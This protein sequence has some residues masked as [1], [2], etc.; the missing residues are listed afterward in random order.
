MA[1][2][3]SFSTKPYDEAAAQADLRAL[4]NRL[5]RFNPETLIRACADVLNHPDAAT[6]A[7]MQTHGPIWTWLTLLEQVVLA[8]YPSGP[9]GTDEPN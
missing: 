2:V 4:R 8:Q 5:R 1:T 3:T 7:R 9:A 6:P